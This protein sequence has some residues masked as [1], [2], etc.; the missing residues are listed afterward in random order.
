MHFII[1]KNRWS[2]IQNKI[3]KKRNRT[4]H[5]FYWIEKKTKILTLTHQ[6]F[7]LWFTICFLY[8]FPLIIFSSSLN[9]ND[10]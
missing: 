4:E 7:Q 3:V 2:R 6:Y 9:I 10:E 5:I 8:I 1:Y